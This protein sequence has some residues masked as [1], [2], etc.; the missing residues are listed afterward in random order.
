MSLSFDIA[1]QSLASSADAAVDERLTG[2]LADVQALLGEDLSWVEAALRDAAR[3]GVEPATAAASHLVELGGKRVRP[4]AVLLSTAC[5]A[6][7]QLSKQLHSSNHGEFEAPL[8]A[9]RHF[10]VAVELVHSATLLHDDVVDDGTVRRGSTTARLLWGNAVSVLAGDALLVESLKLTSLHAPALM[11]ELLET[12]SE[13]VSGE[14]IQL[15]GRRQLDMSQATY[16]EILRL[17]TASLFRLATSGGA[18]L[19][20][21]P[22]AQRAALGNFGERLGMAFQ[23]VDDA[24]DYAGTQS[25]KTLCADLLEGKVTLPLVLA[26]QEDPTILE[27]VK[28]IRAGK[29]ELVSALRQRVLSSG[30]CERVRRR[31]QRETEHALS[32][33]AGIPHGPARSML[34]GVAHQL[35]SRER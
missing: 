26:A 4:T 5:F 8:E 24:L 16:D 34:E 35:A 19:G 25:G 33:L 15:R 21:A 2:R 11:P 6:V 12:L 29:H 18:L 23:L 22:P 9:A 3:A 17:K 31:A 32:A 20:G 28:Q 13:L 1:V 30:A 14:V 10:A 27:C 7:P